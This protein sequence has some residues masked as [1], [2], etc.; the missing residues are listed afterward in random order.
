MLLTL[1]KWKTTMMNKT[2][3]ITADD[4]LDIAAAVENLM[5]TTPLTERYVT[6]SLSWTDGRLIKVVIDRHTGAVR[7]Y[8]SDGT[9]ITDKIIKG[10]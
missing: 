9:D 8:D 7:A 6:A 2:A 4:G 5:I 10:A 3:P 1:K